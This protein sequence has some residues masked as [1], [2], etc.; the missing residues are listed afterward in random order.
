[1]QKLLHQ[2]VLAR[3]VYLLVFLGPDSAHRWRTDLSTNR[4]QTLES[5]R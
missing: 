4:D 1:M 5:S 3:P 2:N